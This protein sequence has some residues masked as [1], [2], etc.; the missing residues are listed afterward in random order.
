ML[1]HSIQI[2]LAV[3]ALE[4]DMPKVAASQAIIDESWIDHEVGAA[5]FQDERLERRF[6]QLI[7]RLAGGTGESMP[8][9]CQ[10]WANTKGAYRFFSNP[11][12]TEADILAGHFSATQERSAAVV[13]GPI[14]ILHDTTDFVYRRKSL[15]PLTRVTLGSY[16]RRRKLTVRGISM[17]SSLALTTEGLPLG[18]AAARFWTRKKFKGTDALKR[19][20]NPTRVPIEAKESMRWL[21][22]LQESSTRLADPGNCVHIADRGGDIYEM[23]S[24]AHEA[25]THFLVRT[26]VD[27]F[28]GDGSWTV[29]NEMEAVPVKGLHRVEV[30]DR[31]GNRSTAIFKLQYRRLRVLPPVAKRDRYPE[32]TVTILHAT[33]RDKPKDRERTDWKLITDPGSFARGSDR[34]T[35]LVRDALEDRGVPQ[36]T[37]VGLQSGRVPIENRGAA[38]EHDRDVLHP[39][40]ADLLDDDDEPDNA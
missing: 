19:R 11:R 34:E 17:H 26:C 6:K 13:D 12:V 28:C 16:F 36:S 33:E 40:L 38:G 27:R 7:G 23:F 3:F 31:K 20:I 29:A 22:N 32:L 15:R 4:S 30:Q 21:L 18:L 25:G 10:D 35:R 8:L 37:E 1:R 9:A 14:L 5:V 24:A 2:D 39:E